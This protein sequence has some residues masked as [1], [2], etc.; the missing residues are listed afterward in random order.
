M[1]D[2]V[3][4]RLATRDD[5]TTIAAMFATDLEGGHGDT[6]DPAAL[7]D[8]FAA[9][10]A[11]AESPNDRLYVAQ[12][13]GLVVGT[14]QTTLIRSMTGRGSA[15]LNVEAVHVDHRFRSKGIG[16]AMMRFAIDEA[17]RAG[18]AKVQLT[19]NAERKAAHRF[20]ERLGFSR[21]HAGFKMKLG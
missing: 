12:I 9:F 7:P 6:A 17:Q 19:S 8:Y 18:C 15:N 2:A 20:Y 11:I 5:V 14:F 4:I 1:T 13:D 3:T 10:G 16:E 21:S